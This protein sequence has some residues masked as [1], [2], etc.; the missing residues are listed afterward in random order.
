MTA[1]NIDSTTREERLYYDLTEW[2][3]RVQNKQYIANDILEK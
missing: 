1:P 2:R 3:F